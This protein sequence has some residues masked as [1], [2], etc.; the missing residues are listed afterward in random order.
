MDHSGR[1][2]AFHAEG[3]TPRPFTVLSSVS[4][5]TL[6]VLSRRPSGPLSLGVFP[7]PSSLVFRR[8]G[9]SSDLMDRHRLLVPIPLGLGSRTHGGLRARRVLV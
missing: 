7:L 6:N 3:D 1:V 8:S 9:P 4:I 2:G 5:Q